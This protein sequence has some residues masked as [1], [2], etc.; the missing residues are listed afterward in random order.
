MKLDAKEFAE[1][2]GKVIAAKLKDGDAIVSALDR[3]AAEMCQEPVSWRF[4]IERDKSG[5]IKAINAKPLT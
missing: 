2:T 3:I 1:L 5:F 4:E